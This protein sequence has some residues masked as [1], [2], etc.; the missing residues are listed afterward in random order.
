MKRVVVLLMLFFVSSCYQ[1][2]GQVYD[3]S[4]EGQ[5]SGEDVTVQ[6]YENQ[7]QKRVINREFAI[8][9]MNLLNSDGSE[10]GPFYVTDKQDGYSYNYDG[11]P[12][13]GIDNKQYAEDMQSGGYP[14]G[15]EVKTCERETKREKKKKNK[16]L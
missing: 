15:E 4:G 12:D 5:M 8:I 14:M 13:V 11:H 10:M 2:F 7:D 9:G 1:L 6:L 3:K 16:L